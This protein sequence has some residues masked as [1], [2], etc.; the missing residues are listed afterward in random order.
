[1][2]PKFILRKTSEYGKFEPEFCTEAAIISAS[3]GS[4]VA[5]SKHLPSFLSHDARGTVQ[6]ASRHGMLAR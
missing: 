5:L 1:M 4:H 6:P 2:I 3:N